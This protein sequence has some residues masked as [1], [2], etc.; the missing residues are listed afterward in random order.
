MAK[1]VSLSEIDPKL[2][3]NLSSLLRVCDEAVVLPQA[4]RSTESGSFKNVVLRLN[5]AEGGL[6]T[7]IFSPN[8]FVGVSLVPVPNDKAEA[9]ISSATKRK[10]I[11]QKLAAAIPSEMA[12]SQLQVGPEVECD[13]QDRDL[14]PWVA[15][16]DSPGCCAGLYSALQN[17]EPELSKT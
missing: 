7:E 5:G 10:S 13:D 12:D 16:F 11:L 3:Q 6:S 14:H 17:R 1:I 2:R 15:G 9:L 8:W 4:A